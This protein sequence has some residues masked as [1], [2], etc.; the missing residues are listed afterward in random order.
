MSSIDTRLKA[1]E[2]AVLQIRNALSSHGSN[3]VDA[4]RR[5]PRRSF[6]LH[7]PEAT[8]SL[9]EKV[10]KALNDVSSQLVQVQEDVRREPARSTCEQETRPLTKDHD[11]VATS[12]RHSYVVQAPTPPT[13]AVSA[14]NVPAEAPDA[15][16][17]DDA[18]AQDPRTSRPS[19]LR[20]RRQFVLSSEQ[21]GKHSVP[22]LAKFAN[23]PA[24]TGVVRV[25][26]DDVDWKDVME[27]IEIPDSPEFLAVQYAPDTAGVSRVR[28]ANPTH[29][30]AIKLPDMSQRVERP[31]DAEVEAFLDEAA[32]APPVDRIFYYIGD[33]LVSDF[34]GLL[35]SGAE[36]CQLPSVSGANTDWWQFGD[37]FSAT[38]FHLEDGEKWY[39]SNLV[40]GGWKLW[41]VIWANHRTKFEDLSDAGTRVVVAPTS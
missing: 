19:S 22:Y 18:A 4:Q 26:V 9:L 11:F 6:R 31:S 7:H 41:I 33:S 35:H 5:A 8:P 39:S 12:E 15:I 36:L 10:L 2:E 37:R 34:D 38:P 27:R 14:E 13:Q 3:F 21:I 20:T 23:D 25:E 32:E 40:F 29:P 24:F 1:L 28:L 30:S 16:G 17:R